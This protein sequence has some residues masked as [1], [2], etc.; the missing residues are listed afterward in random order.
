MAQPTAAQL[1]NYQF[2]RD[3]CRRGIPGL[4]PIGQSTLEHRTLQGTLSAPSPTGNVLYTGAAPSTTDLVTTTT[5]VW[6]VTQP[7]SARAGGGAGADTEIG[8]QGLP[9]LRAQCP[10]IDDNLAPVVIAE[11]DILI[12]AAG[13]KYGVASPTPTP[14]ASMW[15]F[16]L[17]KLR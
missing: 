12:D 2:H 16:E 13:V 11:D 10:F 5:R 14:D 6:A 7:M 17:V 8:R 4:G 15:A 9:M 3:L 1:A